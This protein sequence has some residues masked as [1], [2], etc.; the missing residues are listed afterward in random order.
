[1]HQ[2]GGPRFEDVDILSESGILILVRRLGLP[3]TG[4]QNREWPSKLAL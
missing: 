3:K 1:M 4:S 2:L